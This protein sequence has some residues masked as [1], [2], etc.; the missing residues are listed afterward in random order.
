MKEGNP[1]FDANFDIDNRSCEISGKVI[2]ATNNG[3]PKLS[4]KVCAYD[5]TGHIVQIA[6][7]RKGKYKL[8]NLRPG[9]YAIRTIS[10]KRYKDKWYD[11][12]NLLEPDDVDNKHYFVK[13]PKSVKW[14]SLS[15][16]QVITDTDFYLK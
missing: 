7:V 14:L 13:L 11:N 2:D 8:K 10:G 6:Y 15:E 4:V 1:E 9:K 3:I 12:V 16:G 5:R